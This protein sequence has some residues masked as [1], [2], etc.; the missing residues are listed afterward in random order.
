[1]RNLKLVVTKQVLVL[2][3][4]FCYLNSQG[5]SKVL[6]KATILRGERFVTVKTSAKEI[7]NK[8]S[9]VLTKK[10]FDIITNME[11]AGD[12]LF[13]DLFVYQFPAQY[14]AI[15]ITIRTQNGIHYIDQEYRKVFL[16]REL[17][18][19]N[20][21]TKLA[22]RVPVELNKDLVYRVGIGDLISTNKTSNT[23]L[24]TGNSNYYSTI[25]WKDDNNVPFIVSNDLGL[26]LFYASN[27]TGLKKQLARCPIVLKLRINDSARFELV[28]TN[29][30]LNL[31]DYQ[32][33]RIQEF[34]ESFPLWL[35][36]TEVENIEI[37]YGL[38]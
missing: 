12:L 36:N 34:I 1:M 11:S 30:H 38:K 3:L 13:V 17:T 24:Y 7:E 35:T 5:R 37:M 18:N 31:D 6:I 32:K 10:G 21:A 14:P 2:I 25:K 33:N 4:C 15:T 29:S 8:V 27:F 19:L 20:L 9:E 28:E 23:T 26:Y 22:E 16:D